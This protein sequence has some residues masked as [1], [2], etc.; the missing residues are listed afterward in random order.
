MTLPRPSLLALIIFLLAIAVLLPGISEITGITGKDEYLLGLRTPMHMIEGA[1]G[2]A[3][4][5]T[6]IAKGD[7]ARFLAV[8]EEYRKAK[9]VTRKRLYLETMESVLPKVSE[10]YVIDKEQRS[11]LPLLNVGPTKK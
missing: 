6:N 4:E 10:V 9:E 11:L 5:R 3:I 7:T 2:Y 8:L 1:H